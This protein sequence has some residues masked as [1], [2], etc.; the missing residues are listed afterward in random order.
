MVDPYLIEV[1]GERYAL[2]RQYVEGVAE[3]EDLVALPRS[4]ELLLG[5]A[6]WRG[7]FV[8][9]VKTA[10]L[11]GLPDDGAPRMLLMLAQGGRGA[12]LAV[13]G[14]GGSS[15]PVEPP[16]GGLA[17]GP[18]MGVVR[19]GGPESGEE[20]IWL[21]AER[22]LRECEQALNERGGHPGQP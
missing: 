22:L 8:P 4:P 18:A 7:A 12:A 6:Y 14:A 5:A 17:S 21:D 16:G 10:R 11:L 20:A 3:P 1:A 15:Q 2:D 13:E 19:L 9:V